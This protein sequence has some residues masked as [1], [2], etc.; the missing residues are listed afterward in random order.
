MS[1]TL[2]LP[3]M[4][5]KTKIQATNIYTSAVSV[6][7]ILH[8]KFIITKKKNNIYHFRHSV[9]TFPPTASMITFAPFPPVSSL[10]CHIIKL[11]RDE[12]SVKI[13]LVILFYACHTILVT[14]FGE[15]GVGSI[16]ISWLIF[17]FILIICLLDIVLIL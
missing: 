9:N 3:T 15:L 17:L 8:K 2:F 10:T 6:V 16:T 13:S 1:K 14:L 5:Q 7:S 11:I 4:T 12:E